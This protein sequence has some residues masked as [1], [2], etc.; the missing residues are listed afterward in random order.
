MLLKD[1][2]V[3]IT[4]SNRGIGLEFAKAALTRGAR[5][6]YA[7]LGWEQEYF[8]IDESLI[9]MIADSLP[10]SFSLLKRRDQW[11][12]DRERKVIAESRMYRVTLV[13][14]EGYFALNVEPIEDRRVTALAIHGLDATATSI[15]DALAD[16]GL[17][18]RVRCTGW[19]TGLYCPRQALAA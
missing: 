4:G 16:Q 18:L 3:L 12:A 5:K 17:K 15:F 9:P 6:V 7:T 1:A 10:R 14:W 19:T 13:D 11:W 2:V 8:L